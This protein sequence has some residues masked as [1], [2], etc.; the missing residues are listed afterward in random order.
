M[1]NLSRKPHLEREAR[2][3]PI[4]ITNSESRLNFVTLDYRNV[5]VT[6]MRDTDKQYLVA[7]CPDT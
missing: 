4:W 3:R 1:P 5:V 7:V 6:I 2:V